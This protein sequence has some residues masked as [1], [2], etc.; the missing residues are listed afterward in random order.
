MKKILHF[1]HSLSGGGAEK[2]LRLLSQETCSDEY[3]IYIF[4]IND[5]SQEK[6]NSNVTIIKGSCQPTISLRYLRSIFS[7]IKAV[8]PDIVHIWL[9]AAITIPALFFSA[10]LGKKIIF[11]YRAV[12]EFVRP[13]SYLEYLLVLLVADKII[14]NRPIDD[15]IAPY[16]WLYKLKKGQV[17]YNSVSM[18]E[19]Y[20]RDPALKNNPTRL[21]FVGRLSKPKN[22]L[23]LINALE[24][25]ASSHT[26][27]LDIYGV[28]EQQEEV[29]ALIAHHNLA[30]RIHLKGYHNDVYAEMA[31]SDALVFPSISEGMP[32]TLVEAFA[33]GLPVLASDIVANRYVVGLHPSVIWMNPN[34]SNDMA[35]KIASFIEGHHNAQA[36]IDAGKIVASQY[37]LDRM[38]ND[39]RDCYEKLIKKASNADTQK[40]GMH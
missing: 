13:L 33:I 18:S 25:I 26:W 12:M 32:N 17:I 15:T 37:S 1:I 28:G 19:S 40:I 7:V 29:S 20:H 2:Q 39:Y 4:C 5:F 3:Q 23:Q 24:K 31:S 16:K 10:I 27:Q 38:V 30:A 14:S 21:I 6:L 9:P 35:Q 22:V 11:S 36:L 34:D 8:N